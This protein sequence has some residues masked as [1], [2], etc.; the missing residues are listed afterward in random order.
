MTEDVATWICRWDVA[1]YVAARR[2]IA[3]KLCALLIG[4][5]Q[6]V[7]VSMASLILEVV[8]LAYLTCWLV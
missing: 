6:D 8:V 4:D 7:D 5:V 2:E 1:G 3:T